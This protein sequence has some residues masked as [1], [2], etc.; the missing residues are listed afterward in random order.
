MKKRLLSAVLAIVAFAAIASAGTAQA[1]T[2]WPA[3]CRTMSCVNNHLNNL[4]DRQRSTASRVSQLR[5]QVADLQDRVASLE[6]FRTNA[7][8]KLSCIVSR[9]VWQNYSYDYYGDF[10]QF[11]NFNH[12][13]VGGGGQQDGPFQALFESTSGSCP[14][15]F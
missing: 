12:T 14:G 2:T 4:N 1:A 6:N 13:Y 11:L 15:T 9:T 10:F 7:N 8:A 5:V 3:T